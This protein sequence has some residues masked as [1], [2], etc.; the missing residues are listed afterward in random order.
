MTEKQIL[1]HL[2]RYYSE[3]G[4]CKF[5]THVKNGSTWLTNGELLVI[6]GLA[7]L[8]SYTKPLLTG[9]EIK[10][11]RA[12]FFNDTKWPYYIS[13]GMCNRLYF[14]VPKGLVKKLEIPPE[15]GL[16]TISDD[17]KVS[18]RKTAPIQNIE[19]SSA[20]FQYLVY[21]R[22]EHAE[23]PEDVKDRADRAERFLRE[24]AKRAGWDYWNI[25]MDDTVNIIYE[26]IKSEKAIDRARYS[27]EDA[28]RGLRR[29]TSEVAQKAEKL[30]MIRGGG[31][32]K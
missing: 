28:I 7:V 25:D 20:M 26:G 23:V 27:M 19:L 5:F 8:P 22:L 13:N 29:A 12:D 21:S 11:S 15:V 17:G 16:V 30:M 31:K 4:N 14:V 2:T 1:T 3:K 10:T 32:A 18:F 9:F 24:L 6:D